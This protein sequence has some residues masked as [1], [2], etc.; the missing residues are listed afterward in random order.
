MKRIYFSII[1]FLFALNVKAQEKKSKLTIYK[2]CYKVYVSGIASEEIASAL[3]Q[4][5]KSIDGI[6]KSEHV[7]KSAEHKYTLFKVYTKQ[8]QG[9]PTAE[10]EKNIRPVSHGTIKRVLAKNKLSTDRIEDEQVTE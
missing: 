10:E 8:Y 3:D 7:F 4:E 5:F 2:L 1:V 9:I 6:Y